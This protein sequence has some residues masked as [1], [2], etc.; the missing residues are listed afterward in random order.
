MP[1][2][3]A[4]LTGVRPGL[5]P[6]RWIARPDLVEIALAGQVAAA[7]YVAPLAMQAA[8]PRVP[9]RKAGSAGSAAV[10]ELLA[11]EAFDLFESVDGWAYGRSVADAYVGWVHAEALVPRDDRAQVMVTARVAPVFAAADI[12]APVVME[13]PFGARVSG[14]AG[15]RFF[16]CDAGFI[17]N[18]HLAPAPATPVEVAQLFTGAPYLW[19]GRTPLGV[20]CSGLV[21]AALMACGTACPRDSDQQREAIGTAV[22]L[23]DRRAGDVMFFPGHVGIL[24]DADT[25]LHANA[26]WMAV[27]SEPLADVIARLADS[28]QPVTGVRRIG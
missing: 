26:H 19:G 13:L 11:G 14:A 6:R 15:E 18:R 2:G 10:S 3:T 22:D 28:P 4:Q 20:D 16:V 21:Q 12:K 8:A 24:I 9:M 1:A 25:L 5:D 27:V 7:R 17:H 23:G